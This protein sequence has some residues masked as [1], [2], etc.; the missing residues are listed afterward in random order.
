MIIDTHLHVWELSSDQYPWNPL[1]TVA[2]TYPWSI[3]NEIEV[4][5]RYG[6]DRGILVQPSMYRWDNRYLLEC[7]RRYPDR[8]HLVGLVNPES[9]NVLDEMESL[10]K[11]GVKGLR[12]GPM[13]RPDITWYNSSESDQ[14]W[15]KAGELGLILTLLVIPEQV[16]S[17][18]KAIQRFPMTK[19]VIDHLARP[20]KVVSNE[21]LEDLFT[22]AKFDQVYIKAS[23]LGFMSRMSYPHE[24]ILAV[25]HRT[26]DCFGPQRLMWGTDT[27][28]SQKPEGIPAALK[29]ID[30]AL[31]GAPAQDLDW[32]KG[33]TAAKLFGWD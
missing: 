21:A 10:A 8:F 17:A 19:V 30:L 33:Q 20:D 27:P 6:I 28:M 16:A 25:V 13:L 26:Y 2:P 23:A 14:L 5:E 31:P 18:R 24:D 11:Q 29:L 9:P 12:L 4:M 22:L 1:A 7:A 3:E 15:E 32:I